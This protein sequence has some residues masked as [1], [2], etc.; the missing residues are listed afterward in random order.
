MQNIPSFPCGWA[1][2]VGGRPGAH[3]WEDWNLQVPLNVEG[4][5]LQGWALSRPTPAGVY[6][7]AHLRQAH[8]QPCRSLVQVS[9]CVCF[10]EW[11]LLDGGR[12]NLRKAYS[13]QDRS[14]LWALVV[15]LQPASCPCTSWLPGRENSWE[16][17]HAHM[18]NSEGQESATLT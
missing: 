10:Y 13:F 12:W 8:L 11:T 6:V 16:R 7:G 2:Q 17:T 15:L 18:Y 4:T 3:L 1:W 9:E 14:S 5:C